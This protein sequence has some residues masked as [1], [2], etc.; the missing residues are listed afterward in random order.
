MEVVYLNGSLVPYSQARLS[1]YDYG[2]LHG[3]GLFETM[4]SYS[5]HIFRARQHLERLKRS[6]E[7]IGINLESSIPAL[8]AALY[9]T[10]QAN[11]L[12]N[13]R[14]RLTVSIGEGSI[15]P[16]ISSCASP[17][18]FISASRFVSQTNHTG[19]KAIVSNIRR[20]SQ[21]PL[22]HIKSLN[23][24][25]NIL[26]RNEANSMGA[27]QAILLNEQGYIAESHSSNIFFVFKGSLITPDRDS[28]ILPG[29]TRDVVL[30]LSQALGIEVIERKIGLNEAIKAD[31]IFIT[32]SI[33][34][35]EAVSHI[36]GRRIASGRIGETTNRLIKA[37]SSL[38]QE[39]TTQW[40]KT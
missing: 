27:D 3:Y 21:S 36:S 18:T 34:E 29:I 28:G 32:N 40:S 35:I 9:Q 12:D 13:A 39:E 33:V 7:L 14:I 11:N 10:I 17:T 25:D 19:S 2:F 23:G 6:A 5:G 1:P 8:E 37:Y 22:C 4:R 38:V 31:E 26:A 20:N 24:M 30:E 15:V 16:N